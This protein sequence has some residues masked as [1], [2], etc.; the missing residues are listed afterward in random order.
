MNADDRYDERVARRLDGEPIALSDAERALADALR[1]D[2]DRL[3]K[4]LPPVPMPAE[5]R[6]RATRRLRAALAARRT[7]RRWAAA[8]GAIA[9]AAAVVVM[10]VTLW[11]PSRE[12]ART[13]V[14]KRHGA[15]PTRAKPSA[16]ATARRDAAALDA[17]L[18]EDELSL[19]ARE[20]ASLAGEMALDATP[21]AIEM[22]I[23]AMEDRID[24]FEAEPLWPDEG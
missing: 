2:E 3:A 18:A 1:R 22:E 5:A 4:H 10:T 9:A 8:T 21:D 6:A 17:I 7:R 19:V 20:I 16:L 24:A 15:T 12:P 13:D 14:A 23:D 11:A